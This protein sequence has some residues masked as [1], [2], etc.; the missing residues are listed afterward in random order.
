MYFN[1]CSNQFDLQ[2]FLVLSNNNKIQ[3]QQ[4]IHIYF[5]MNENSTVLALIPVIMNNK[6]INSMTITCYFINVSINTI[7]ISIYLVFCNYYSQTIQL[8]KEEICTK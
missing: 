7:I 1:R 3:M 6:Y 8:K 4:V 5:V 2:R